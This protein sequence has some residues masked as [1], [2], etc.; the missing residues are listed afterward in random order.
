M[1][2]KAKRPI[3]V[4]T[5]W[6]QPFWDAAKNKQ[7]GIQRCAQCGHYNHPPLPMCAQCY[8]DDLKCEPV[9]G[10]G[11][12]YQWVIMRQARVAGFEEAIPFA[13][14]A[15]ELEEQPG[16]VVMANLLDAPPEAAKV[17]L[18]VEVTFEEMDGKFLLPQFRPRTEV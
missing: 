2:S 6:T 9:S 5:K 1:L 15:V 4:P 12:I 13:C 17:G 18:P 3:P 10:R 16:L 8:S 14:I 7:L 11:V